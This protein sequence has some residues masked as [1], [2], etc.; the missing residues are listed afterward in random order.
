MS[1]VLGI[2]VSTEGLRSTHLRAESIPPFAASFSRMATASGPRPPA[3]TFMATTPTPA[4]CSDFMSAS[5]R[6]PIVKL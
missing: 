1:V 3:I 6:S 5:L 2:V 4:S